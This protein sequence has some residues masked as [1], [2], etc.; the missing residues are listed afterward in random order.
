MVLALKTQSQP[1]MN[2][3]AA[4]Q[5]ILLAI[6]SV[7]QPHLEAILHS[8]SADARKA[9]IVLGFRLCTIVWLAAVFTHAI[10]P[11]IVTAFEVIAS[12]GVFVVAAIMAVNALASE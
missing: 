7:A 1:R 4:L 10:F 2:F 12:T 9:P 3:R 6:A 5:K 8:C 11:Q